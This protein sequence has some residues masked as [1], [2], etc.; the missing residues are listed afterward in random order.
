MKKDIDKRNYRVSNKK[1]ESTGYKNLYSIDDGIKEL[2]KFYKAY[3]T[4]NASN[5]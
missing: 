4:N 2:V 3:K 5:V 1:L